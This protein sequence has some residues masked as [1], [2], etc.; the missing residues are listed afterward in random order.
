MGV[1]FTSAA[2]RVTMATRIRKIHSNVSRRQLPKVI[3]RSSTVILL[4]LSHLAAQERAETAK[5]GRPELVWQGMLQGTHD[6]VIQ[7]DQV[8]VEDISGPPIREARYRFVT[9][10]PATEAKVDVDPRVSRGWVHTT[11]EPRMDNG[12]TLRVRIEDRQSGE[13]FYSLAITWRSLYEE[14][15]NFSMTKLHGSR[16]SAAP[17]DAAWVVDGQREKLSCGAIWSG[18]VSGKA[19]IAIGGREARVLQGQASGD[20]EAVGGTRWP[21]GAY[22]PIVMATSAGTRVE[23]VENPATKNDYTLVIEVQAEQP[24]VKI[25]I[26]W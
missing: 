15:D 4:T 6:L 2:R 8:Q 3:L 16:K 18:R 21:K 1:Y 14:P 26:A 22:V 9:P 25:E 10:L 5:L 19:R 24:V 12:Y 11:Q 23:V 7:N 20:L 17:R 13:Y